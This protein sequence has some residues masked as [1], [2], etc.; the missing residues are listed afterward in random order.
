MHPILFVVWVHVGFNS[1]KWEQKNAAQFFLTLEDWGSSHGD[2]QSTRV[3][4]IR[5]RDRGWFWVPGQSN[6]PTGLLATALSHGAE[7]KNFLRRRLR[8]HSEDLDDVAQ[9]VF[10]RL[11][12]ADDKRVLRNPIGYVYGVARHVLADFY[13]GRDESLLYFDDLERELG[14]L[15]AELPDY[16]DRLNLQQQLEEQIKTLPPM[17]A[18]VLLLTKRDGLTYEEVAQ[19]LGLSLPMVH[20][21]VTWAKAELRTMHWER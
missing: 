13:D 16:G 6:K 4:P 9:E 15:S 21:Y 17:Q 20:K 12:R 11:L 5:R 7:L 14:E 3:Y 10:I 18:T 8:R 1:K 2:S 19:T